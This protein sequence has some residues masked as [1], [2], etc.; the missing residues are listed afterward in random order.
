MCANVTTMHR[1]QEVL[2]RL[3]SIQALMIALYLFLLI[4]VFVVVV[5]VVFLQ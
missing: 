4:F 5:V 2:F 3:G 1:G